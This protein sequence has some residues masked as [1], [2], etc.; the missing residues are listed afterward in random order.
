MLVHPDGRQVDPDF[1]SI[2]ARKAVGSDLE[3]EPYPDDPLSEIEGPCEEDLIG[4]ELHVHAQVAEAGAAVRDAEAAVL[5]AEDAG[6]PDEVAMRRLEQARAA[7]WAV[8]VGLQK[9]RTEATESRRK[10]RP[11]LSVL[12]GGEAA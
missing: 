3:R 11:H 12:R 5:A 4:E 1:F 2:R 8:L 10:M 6:A 7:E 9:A